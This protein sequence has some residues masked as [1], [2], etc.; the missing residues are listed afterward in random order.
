[1]FER[2]ILFRGKRIGDGK[3]IVGYYTGP[4]A[5]KVESHW[6]SDAGSPFCTPYRVDPATVG[7]YTGLRD[8]NGA[9]IF[10]GDI[11][12]CAGAGGSFLCVVDVGSVTRTLAEAPPGAGPGPVRVRIT[13]VLL[14]REG[15]GEPPLVDADG[16]PDTARMEIVGNIHDDPE[17]VR[18]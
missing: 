10:V 4:G 13:G 17:L 14:I 11:A 3:W 1:M 15:R 7:Q 8:R 16:V 2:E 18:P 12:R 6:I 5:G 9:R